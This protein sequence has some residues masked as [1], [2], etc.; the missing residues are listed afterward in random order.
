MRAAPDA[1]ASRRACLR[2]IWLRLRALF[3]D[4]EL[5]MRDPVGTRK[6]R[7]IVRS[8]R[9]APCLSDYSGRRSGVILT[10]P[11]RLAGPAPRDLCRVASS[12]AS[13]VRNGLRGTIRPI[14]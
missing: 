12:V 13:I 7:P 14:G 5:F 8:C 2:K 6:D 3:C 11:V 4:A 10:A 1:R 9:S